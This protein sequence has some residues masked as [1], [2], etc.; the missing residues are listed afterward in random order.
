MRFGAIVRLAVVLCGAALAGMPLV[1]MELPLLLY[2]LYNLVMIAGEMALMIFTV[3]ICNGEGRAASSVFTLNFAL[4]MGTACASSLFFYAMHVLVGGH[5]AWMITGVVA[6][7]AI[8]AVI[9]FLPSRSSDAVVLMAETLPENEGYEANVAMKRSLMAQ[10]YSL[11]EG[12]AVVLELLMQGKKRERIADELNLS[13]WTVKART[14]SIYKKCGV[15]SY[16]ELI[17][18]ISSDR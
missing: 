8:L 2:P 1:S 10:R 18:L 14:S 7:W 9:P 11:S 16:K 15:H 3:D 6:V 4:F 17:Q 5:M 12:E 13:P